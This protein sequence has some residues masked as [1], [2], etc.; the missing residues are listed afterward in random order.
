MTRIGPRPY[1]AS[2]LPDGRD[3]SN[4]SRHW[5]RW[6]VMQRGEL[7]TKLH[8]RY[9]EASLHSRPDF[10]WDSHFAVQSEVLDTEEFSGRV[11]FA[12]EFS[13]QVK[14]NGRET[15]RGLRPG[16]AGDHSR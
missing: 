11:N 12:I 14:I 2:H 10:F 15:H 4:T 13:N 6:F 8:P 3:I 16:A 7:R 1:A 9:Y 5:S